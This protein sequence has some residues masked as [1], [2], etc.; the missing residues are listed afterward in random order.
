MNLGAGPSLFVVAY[1]VASFV[2]VGEL[3]LSISYGLEERS[4]SDILVFTKARDSLDGAAD[5][6][7]L[8]VP[9]SQER[10]SFAHKGVSIKK[11]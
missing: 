9:V 6:V 4:H 5:E 2:V 3:W 8:L 10:I 1:L 7:L 11:V